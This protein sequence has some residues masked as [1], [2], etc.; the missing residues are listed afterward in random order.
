MSDE[1]T[2]SETKL[3]KLPKNNWKKIDIDIH[4]ADLPKHANL[5]REPSPIE[6]RSGRSINGKLVR[7]YGRQRAN[8]LNE[9]NLS[10]IEGSVGDSKNTSYNSGSNDEDNDNECYW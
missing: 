8:T 7:K 5:R 1:L 9:S 4:Y 3:A 2:N 10:N 6:S